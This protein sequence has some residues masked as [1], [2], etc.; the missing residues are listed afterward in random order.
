MTQEGGIKTDHFLTLDFYY[1][2]GSLPFSKNGPS[3]ES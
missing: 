1:N 2:K 3:A